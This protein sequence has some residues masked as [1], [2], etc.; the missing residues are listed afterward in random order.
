LQGNYRENKIQFFASETWVLN[1]KHKSK[2]QTMEMGFLQKVV[3]KTRCD[4][5]RNETIRRNLGV[6]PLQTEIEESQ[7]RWA[8][9]VLRMGGEQIAWKVFEAK[10]QGGSPVGRPR[11]MWEEQVSIVMVKIVAQDRNRWR[12]LCRSLDTARKKRV[13]KKKKLSLLISLYPHGSHF[14]PLWFIHVDMTTHQTQFILH[15]VQTRL[16][17]T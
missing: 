12:R 8:E 3:G 16:G 14:N 11:Q 4:K 5:I 6:P 7:L 15:E 17:P 9:Y 13:I 2:I 1:K 10:V